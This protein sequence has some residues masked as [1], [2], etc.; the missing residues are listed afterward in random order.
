LAAALTF[1]SSRLVAA[2]GDDTLPS[3]DAQASPETASAGVAASRAVIVFV[4]DAAEEG[5]L[6]ELVREFLGRKGVEVE[7]SHAARF[8][9]DAL[10]E[11]GAEST[12]V[13]VFVRVEPTRARLYFRGPGGARFLLRT[14]PL[15][16]GLDEVGR[17]LVGQVV[18]SSVVTL[19]NTSAGLSREQAS[20]EVALESTNEDTPP[21]AEPH[22]EPSRA[23]RPH[24]PSLALWF[25]LRYSVASSGPD[26]E[27]AHG[28]G[29]EAGVGTRGALSVRARVSVDRFFEQDLRT[30]EL[31]ATVQQSSFRASVD[32]GLHLTKEQLAVLAFGASADLVRIEPGAPRAGDVTPAEPDSSVV[33]SLR[34]ELRYEVALGALSLAASGFVD[35]PLERTHYDLEVDGETEPVGTPWPVRPGGALVLGFCY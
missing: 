33:P 35:V 13:R 28:P 34:P 22:A 15:P 18:E 24:E 32:L 17:E 16:S 2:P 31:D 10:F 25:A 3:N 26:F 19:L 30:T 21:K 9:P 14:I 23:P 20:A 6:D 4:G 29:A 27:L 1:A 12:A 5:D 11:D 8:E 7:S